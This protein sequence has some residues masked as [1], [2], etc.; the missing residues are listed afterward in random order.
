MMLNKH[1]VNLDVVSQVLK[2]PEGTTCLPITI[3]DSITRSTHRD[4]HF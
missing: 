4:E 1:V 2:N 3:P